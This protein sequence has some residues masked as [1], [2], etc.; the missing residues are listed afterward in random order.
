MSVGVMKDSKLK[1]RNLRVSHTLGWEVE[2]SSQVYLQQDKKKAEA[3][4]KNCHAKTML[5]LEK[6][7]KL[8][9]KT[10]QKHPIICFSFFLSSSGNKKNQQILLFIYY[11]SGTTA[12]VLTDVQ[13][14]SP[15][16]SV[17]KEERLVFLQRLGARRTCQV[18]DS[19]ASSP[20][21]LFLR[22]PTFPSIL[23]AQGEEARSL[24]C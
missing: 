15:K 6:P 8:I 13:N 4:S 21:H 14:Q 23:L 22:L 16:I 3:E 5:S 11:T 2:V 10:S 17:S 19:H 20:V 9:W 7:I 18:C 1:L 12:T 24:F